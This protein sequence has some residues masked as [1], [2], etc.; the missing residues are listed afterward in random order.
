ML[1]VPTPHIEANYGEIAKKVLMPGDPLRAKYIAENFLDDAR[2]VN[3]VRNM[4][5]Y[6]GTYKGEEITVMGSGMGCPSIGIY[7]YELFNGYDVDLIIRIGTAGGLHPKLNIGDIVIGQAACTDS[8]YITQHKFSGAFA[9]IGD[10]ATI[11]SL[12][13]S[14]T[15]LGKN[16][17]VGNIFSSDIFYNEKGE[18]WTKLGVLAVEMEA[19]ALYFNAVK[20]NK[21]AVAMCTISDIPSK[22]IGMSSEEREKSLD[23]MIK[24]ALES[25]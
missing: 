21:K 2:L 11:M 20:A 14:A 25:Q 6:T 13:N 22:G 1:K 18:D 17:H 23:D 4:F 9:P 7:S 3:K 15:K 24:I 5:A 10:F 12:Y 16:V 8:A 19:A